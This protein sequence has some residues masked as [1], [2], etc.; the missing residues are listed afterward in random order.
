MAR[1]G[2]CRYPL[3][4]SGLALAKQEEAPVRTLFVVVA[5]VIVRL[6]GMAELAMLNAMWRLSSVSLCRTGMPHGRL[7][8]QP[9][10]LVAAGQV[11]HD[12]ERRGFS[13]RPSGLKKGIT[14]VTD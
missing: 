10:S 11:F 8:Y 5:P 9:K 1:F 12:S 4:T 3:K 13:S 2:I 14:A 6:A 7:V